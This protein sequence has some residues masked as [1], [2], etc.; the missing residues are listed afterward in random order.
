MRGK[1]EASLAATS[2][3]HTHEDVLKLLLAGADATM[4]T[5]A[6]LRKG[7]GHARVVLQ[8]MA[9]WLEAK[10]YESVEQL[11]GSMSRSNVPDPSAFERAN[12]MHALTTFVP[13]VH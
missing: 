6:F 3:C 9:A 7:P 12:Y 5:S 11:K 1:V 13:K 2:G 4:M 10:E 8:Q